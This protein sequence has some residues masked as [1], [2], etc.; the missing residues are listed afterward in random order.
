M[1][2][3]WKGIYSSI[4]ADFLIFV[5][6]YDQSLFKLEFTQRQ[7]NFTIIENIGNLQ[8]KAEQVKIFYQS[9]QEL[10]V[11]VHEAEFGLCNIIIVVN[12]VLAEESETT[13]QTV[14]TNRMDEVGN[15]FFLAIS[16]LINLGVIYWEA[17]P[18]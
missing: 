3:L 15:S 13:D 9:L 6:K 11:L 2:Q 1:C 5:L 14:S 18:F 16:L 4:E 10:R 17:K 8:H 7:N 12:E